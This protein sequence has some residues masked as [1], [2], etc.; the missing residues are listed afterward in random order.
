M[1]GQTHICLL[2][3]C[4]ALKKRLGCALSELIFGTT[5]HL[6]DEFFKAV[7]A[8]SQMRPISLRAYSHHGL[9]VT[10]RNVTSQI[11]HCTFTCWLTD[12]HV[13]VHPPWC[14]LPPYIAPTIDPWKG[15]EVLQVGPKWPTVHSMLIASNL[16][17]GCWLWC[18]LGERTSSPWWNIDATDSTTSQTTEVSTSGRW[19]A[20]LA[21]DFWTVIDI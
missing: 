15:C 17:F 16:P 4:S 18:T 19:Q 2:G 7:S 3:L 20:T 9:T 6:P 14:P 11:G 8:L 12:L 13:C 10:K 1:D 21:A 5:I